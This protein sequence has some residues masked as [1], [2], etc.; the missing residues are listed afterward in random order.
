M[1]YALPSMSRK[2]VVTWLGLI[3]AFTLSIYG[4][5]DSIVRRHA[6]DAVSSHQFQRALQILDPLL[7]ANPKDISA[8]A[9]RGLALDGLGRTKES[10]SSFDHALTLDKTYAPALEGAAQTAYLHGDS[11]AGEYVQRLLRVMPDNETANAMAAAIAYQSHDCSNT[12]QYFK[13]SKSAVYQSPVALSEFADC[14]LK[15]DKVAEAV[16]VLSRG[17]QLHAENVQLKYNLA[18]AQMRAQDP[19]AAIVTLEPLSNE[20]D[21]GLLNLLASAYSRAHQ[22][23]DAFRVLENAIEIS[24][25]DESNY[26]DLAILCLEHN[27]EVRAATAATAGIARLHR[28]TSLYLIR[29]IA[30][31]QLAQYDKAENDF[32]AAAELEPNQPHSTIAMSL[33]YSDKNELG[34]EKELLNKQLKTTPNDATAN[35]L[36]ADLLIRSGAMPGQP[37]YQEAQVHLAKSLDAKPDSAEAQILMGK[38]LEQQKDLPGA[39]KHFQA[40]LKVEPEN[41]SA[42]NREFILLRKLHRDQE[43]NEALNQLKSLLNSELK[44]ETNPKQMRVN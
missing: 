8:W 32:T 29:G 26:L 14:L 37:A 18:V 25:K 27:Q 20:K 2:P 19:K 5:D 30:Y 35:Y 10:L 4:E 16:S 23:D 43:A 6:A 7:K 40:A 39:L 3:L 38:L 42:L 28:A 17:S 1:F 9:L 24:P 22:P 12:V 41:R 15:S 36:L 11:R 13:R 33:L 21:S 34:K 31:A 44:Q